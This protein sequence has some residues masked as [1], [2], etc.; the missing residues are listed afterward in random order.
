MSNRTSKHIS[1]KHSR[2]P[3]QLGES[4]NAPKAGQNGL[5]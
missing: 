4:P 2:A 5:N 1:K 3:N